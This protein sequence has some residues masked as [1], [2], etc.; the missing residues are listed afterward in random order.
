LLAQSIRL[1]LGYTKTDFEDKHYECGDGPTFDRS[2]WYNVKETLGF[3]FPNLP[4]LIDGDVKITQSNAI[5]RYIARKNGM[6][7]ET[8]DEK[9]QIDILEN[10]LMDFRNDFVMMLYFTPPDLYE[11]KRQEYIKRNKVFLGRLSKYLGDKTFF[12]GKKLTFVDF[13]IYELLD[14]HKLFEISMFENCQNL[15][16]FVSKFENIPEIKEFMSSE[17]FF[18]GPINN[19]DALFK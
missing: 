18:K 11:N 10:Q 17:K 7:G 6:V 16:D 19:K 3:D 13:I 4:Y 15:L 1:L 5:H 8:D 9:L 14:Q 2:C 12:V